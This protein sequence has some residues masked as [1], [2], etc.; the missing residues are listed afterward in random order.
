VRAE[1]LD[2]ITRYEVE[3]R[4]GKDKIKMVKWIQNI[5]GVIPHTNKTVSIALN[6]RNLIVT[7]ANGSG[8]TSFLKALYEK[9]CLY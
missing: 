4:V 6:G 3:F 5:S 7:G 9:V 1:G 2:F 8:K